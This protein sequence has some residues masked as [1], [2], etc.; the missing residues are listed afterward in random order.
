MKN[1]IIKIIKDNYNVTDAEANLTARTLM[2]E[3]DLEHP[4]GGLSEEAVIQLADEVMAKSKINKKSI[5]AKVITKLGASTTEY[6]Q[7]VANWESEA[8]RLSKEFDNAGSP[9]KDIQDFDKWR[10]ETFK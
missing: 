9:P 3:Y 10:E 8:E 1:K 2:E 4:N 7:A 6:Q 5:V